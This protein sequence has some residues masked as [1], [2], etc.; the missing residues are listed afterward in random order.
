MPNLRVSFGEIL[1]NVET[2]VYWHHISDYSSDVLALLI[3]WR[4]WESALLA[5]LLVW[6]WRR[7]RVLQFDHIIQPGM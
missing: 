1:S 5:R 2:W 6:P 4:L 7:Y 3:G